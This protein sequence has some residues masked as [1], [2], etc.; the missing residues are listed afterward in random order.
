[1]GVGKAKVPDAWVGL[2]RLAPVGTVFAQIVDIK[3]LTKL[4]NL[5]TVRSAL[6][7]VHR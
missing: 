3:W 1:V 4:V 2:L 7:V 5:A 6:N